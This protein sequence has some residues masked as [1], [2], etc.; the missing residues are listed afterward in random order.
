MLE[1]SKLTI[2]VVPLYSMISYLPATTLFQFALV[3]IS[4]KII[5]GG[6]P[7]EMREITVTNIIC[8]I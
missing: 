7:K 5:Y 1:L 4:F 8:F 2:Q 6:I 3:G